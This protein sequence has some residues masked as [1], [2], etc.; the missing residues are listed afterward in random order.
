MFP[1]VCPDMDMHSS[2]IENDITSALQAIQYQNFDDIG[3]W[4][5]H[6]DDSIH[7]HLIQQG[8]KIIFSIL[9]LISL[10]RNNNTLKFV[11]FNIKRRDKT[12]YLM[13]VLP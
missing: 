9:I 10:K 3:K 11:L 5:E 4:P 13:M 6:I 12:A 2:E 8:Q 7:L 1:S